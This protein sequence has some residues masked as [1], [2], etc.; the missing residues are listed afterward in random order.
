MGINCCDQLQY[1]F[2]CQMWSNEVFVGLGYGT[3][4]VDS[5]VLQL[6][7]SSQYGGVS[8]TKNPMMHP[9][10]G[11][12]GAWMGHGRSIGGEWLLH[13][14]AGGL[15]AGSAAERGGWRRVDAMGVAEKL[16]M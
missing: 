14:V 3:I 2:S 9:D 1:N 7:R 13:D 11:M 10:V 5:T 12:G 4:Y 15:Q 8:P 6:S 16:V